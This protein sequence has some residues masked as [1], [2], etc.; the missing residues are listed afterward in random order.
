MSQVEKT[1][2]SLTALVVVL[3]GLAVFMLQPSA[4]DASTDPCSALA[5]LDA[6]Y[7]SQLLDR[8]LTDGVDAASLDAATLARFG[9]DQISADALPCLQD[10]LSGLS[11][12]ED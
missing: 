3:V 2:S 12:S 1:V 4:S 9:D 11:S 6:E 10:Q 7:V 5:S 8:M